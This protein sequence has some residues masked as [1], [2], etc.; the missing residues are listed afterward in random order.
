MISFNSKG[1]NTVFL[2][3]AN[4]LHNSYDKLP[5]DTDGVGIKNPLCLAL[6]LRAKTTFPLPTVQSV[7]ETIIISMGYVVSQNHR[8]YLILSN[9]R[10][11]DLINLF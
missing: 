10:K 6:Y 7:C 8:A 3:N 2:N 9:P 11:T 4:N 1:D 5:V